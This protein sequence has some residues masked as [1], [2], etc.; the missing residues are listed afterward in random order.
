[1]VKA[2]E[3]SGRL[4]GALRTVALQMEQSYQLKRKIRGALM[5]P[6]IVITAMVIVGILMLIFVVPTLTQTFKELNI[7][8]PLS[9]RIVIAVSDILSRYSIMS[10]TALVAVIVGLVAFSR[11]KNGRKAW[12]TTVLH[13]PIISTLVKETNAARTARTLSSLL[14]S[15]VDVVSALK[16]TGDVLQNT[17][18]RDIIREAEKKIQKG[19]QVSGTFTAH[20]DLYPPMVGEMVAV[21]EE[22]G[23]L[24]DMLL[25]IAEFFEGE[26]AQKTKDLSTIIEP[27]LMIVIG[28]VVGFFAVSMISPTYSLVGGL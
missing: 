10:L 20:E 7:D 8:L 21:G 1:M 25:Q 24:P 26:V 9:T 15:G 28:I 22:T 27:L 19:E 3:E 17:R 16:I 23:K 4:A 18:Y 11:T 5:Y 13:L 6:T 12:S 14:S 2:G